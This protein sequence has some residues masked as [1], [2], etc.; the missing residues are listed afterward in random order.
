MRGLLS[1][2]AVIAL[3]LGQCVAEILYAGVNSG[4]SGIE[5][6]TERNANV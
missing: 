5:Y 2:G 4:M 3:A 1:A 6:V